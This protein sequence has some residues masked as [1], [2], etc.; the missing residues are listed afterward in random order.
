MSCVNSW[1]SSEVEKRNTNSNCLTRIMRIVGIASPRDSSIDAPRHQNMFGFFMLRRL[2]GGAP[3][4]IPGSNPN[5]SHDSSR[6]SRHKDGS[7]VPHNSRN[8][9]RLKNAQTPYDNI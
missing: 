4:Q 6:G 2:T 9:G 1:Q 5:D 3:L 7:K 8:S